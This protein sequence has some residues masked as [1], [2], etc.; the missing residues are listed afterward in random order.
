M[1]DGSPTQTS[2]SLSAAIASARAAGADLGDE[3]FA[4]LLD[5]VDP[6]SLPRPVEI[7]A[8]DGRALRLAIDGAHDEGGSR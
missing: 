5:G 4:R 7:V 3:A 6:A 2:R 1:S 8:T